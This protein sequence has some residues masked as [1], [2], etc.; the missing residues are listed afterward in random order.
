MFVQKLYENTKCLMNFVSLKQ[1]FITHYF[2][3]PWSKGK[4]PET[5]K[6]SLRE[7]LSQYT[8]HLQGEDQILRNAEKITVHTG[9]RIWASVIV[10]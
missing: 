4:K 7:V 10:H 2:G 5:V 1:S 6:V 9:Y 8:L 3:L